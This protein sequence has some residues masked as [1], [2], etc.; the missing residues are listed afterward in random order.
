MELPPKPFYLEA[1]EF[2]GEM[3]VL[4][5]GQ[6]NASVV[7]LTDCHLLGLKAD[8]FKKLLAAHPAIEQSLHAVIAE[9]AR[10]LGLASQEDQVWRPAP[11]FSLP[12]RARW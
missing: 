11:I 10:Q 6:R 12:N 4:S 5:G 9:R 3:A 2:F 1:G 8:D 7:A